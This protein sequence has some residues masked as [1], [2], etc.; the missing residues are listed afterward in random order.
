M[1]V[2][3]DRFENLRLLFRRRRNGEKVLLPVHLVLAGVVLVF[4]LHHLPAPAAEW[5]NFTNVNA[6]NDL[7]P[8]GSS[9]WAATTGGLVRFTNQSV[10]TFTNADGLGDNHLLFVIIDSAGRLW[11]GGQ[12]GRLSL[13]DPA[14]GSWTF[15]DFIDRDGQSLR[16]TAAAA[17]E[18]L[19]W[20]GSDVGIHKFDTEHYGGE[21]T[22]TYRRFGGL[23]A[24]EAVNDVMIVGEYIWVATAAGCAVARTDDI[25]LQDYSHWRSFSRDNSALQDDNVAALAARNG[26]IFAATSAGLYIFTVDGPDSTWNRVPGPEVAFYDLFQAPEEILGATAQGV[27]VCSSDECTLLPTEGMVDARARAVCR[28]GDGNIWATSYQGK[29]YSLYGGSSWVDSVVV[30]PGSN[31]VHDIA[32]T[33]DGSLWAVHPDAPTS[34]WDRSTWRQIDIFKGGPSINSLAVD[35]EGYLWLGGHG[36]GATRLNPADPENDYEHFDETNSP[37]RGA[38]PPPSDWYIVVHD[39]VVDDSGRVW[40]A[41]AFDY[42]DRILVF[43]DHGCWGYF[44]TGDGFPDYEPYAL[45]PLTNE[46]LIGFTGDGLADMDLDTTVSLCVGG[47]Q[48]PQTPDIIFMDDSNGLPTRQVRCLLVDISRKVW[49][50][51]SGGL[52]YFDRVWGRFRT[53]ALGDIAAPT[54]NALVA[55]GGN[56]L[57]V[58][59]DEGLFR[60]TPDGRVTHYVPENSGLVDRQVTSLVIDEECETLWV[61][62]MGGISQF[63]GAAKCATP[64][65]EILAY[66]NPFLISDGDEILKFDAAF[67]TTIRIFTAAGEF[68]ADI[69]TSVEWN[70]RNEAGKLVAGGIYVFV[71]ADE[72]GNY[73]RGKFAV[74]RR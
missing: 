39:I 40:L 60:V 68:V 34:T 32:V 7:L 48:F 4:L 13:L 23:P 74:I 58:G 47:T 70:G 20:V 11:T 65:A 5:R 55:D 21:I 17:D 22:E 8:D 57:W 38:E 1:M 44:G 49:A 67:G 52:A 28:S 62:T 66:P 64:I 35:Q 71:A 33:P 2:M 27:A 36:I 63:I 19:I 61:G 18:N 43:Y 51:T 45:F 3:N 72:A 24:D 50:G 12:A 53:I 73:A 29:G 56:N 14:D 42:E 46:L 10:R 9:I 31:M 6:A 26:A 37:L 16:L 69:G 15:Y 54:V 41:N 59:A 30:G 25:N